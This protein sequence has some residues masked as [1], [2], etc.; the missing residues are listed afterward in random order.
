MQPEGVVLHGVGEDAHEERLVRATAL[1]LHLLDER[2]LE[3]LFVTG[4]DALC[5]SLRPIAKHVL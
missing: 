1:V 4:V 5:L 2:L 3:L